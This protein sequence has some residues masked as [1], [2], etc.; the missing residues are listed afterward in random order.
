MRCYFRVC[1]STTGHRLINS[2]QKSPRYD[3][4]FVRD[5]YFSTIYLIAKV[6]TE[7]IFKM[8][9]DSFHV[10]VFVMNYTNM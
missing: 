7:Y 8:I 10:F 1:K 5:L 9:Y 4:A 3:D 6:F 2:N